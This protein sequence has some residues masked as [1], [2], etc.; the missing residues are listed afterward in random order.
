[1]ILFIF[2]F[3]YNY[4]APLVDKVNPR[5]YEKE[6]IRAWVY[7]TDKGI[8]IDEYSK[9]IQ[10]VKTKMDMM[11]LRR[12]TLRKG[13]IDYGDIPINEDYIGEVEAIGGL[14]IKKS[15][16][17]NAASFW[18]SRE[19]LN[20]IADLNFVYKITPVAYYRGPT[21]TEV[22]I[23]DTAIYG[24]SY[25]QLKMFN[26]NKLHEKTILGSN[27]KIGF[28]DT[29]LRKRHIALSNI[30]LIAE[31]DFLGGDQ[32]Y[33]E[34]IPISE[35]S[36]VYGGVVAHNASNKIYLFFE[37]D[38]FSYNV[39]TRDIMYTYS[40]DG[41]NEWQLIKRLTHNPGN[42][43]VSQLA[44][45][46]RDTIFVFYKD[47]TGIEYLIISDTAVT[48]HTLVSGLSCRE[49]TAVQIDDTIYVFYQNHTQLFMKKGRI[50]GFM[51]E[52]IV[53]SSVWDIKHPKT[54]R[55]ENKIGIFYYTYSADSLYLLRSPIPVTTFTKKFVTFGRD[56]EAILFGD[57]T[58][59]IYKDCSNPPLLKIGF[60]KSLDFGNAFLSPIILSDALNS[61]GRISLIKVG[62]DITVMWESEG[63]IY[64]RTSFNN[65]DNFGNLDSL[66]KEFVY[67][68]TLVTNLSNI[69]KVYCQRGDSITDG[70]APDDPD[71]SH[72]R[73]GTEMLG[74]VGGYFEHQYWGVA[75]G[76]QFLVA[77]TENPNKAYE[78]PV[79]E[80]T[81]ISG[82]EWCE[83]K[84]V[85]I[86]SSSLGYSDW[87]EWPIDYDGRAS[88]ASL[89]AYEATKRGIIIVNASGNI[90]I[91][92]SPR[93]VIPGDAEGV[94]T[95]GGIDTL[96]NH[97]KSDKVYAG[98]YPTPGHTVKKP[99]IVCLSAAPV[100]VNPDTEDIYLYSFGTSGATAIVSGI[101]ALLL[102]GHPNWNVDSVR[103]A[104]FNRASLISSPSDSMGY[105][106]PDALAAF[107]YSPSSIDTT[108][109]N[110]FLTPYPNPFIPSQ[111][112][113]I[114]I[115]F[116]LNRAAAVEIR[117]Y[118]VN[119]RIIKKEERPGMLQPG[120][121]TSKDPLSPNAAFIWDG[122]DENE[123]YVPSGIYY[124]L[125]MTRGGGNALTKIAVVR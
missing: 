109:G 13:I 117:V 110:I 102:E 101:C 7:F 95:V 10:A 77:K 43:W 96:F 111:H 92:L 78:F 66:N 106:W 53:D 51:P 69:I 107:N 14:L 124:C 108:P 4:R 97:W 9:A 21:E 100:V 54:V 23:Q 120:R 115:P 32:I 122:K 34:N 64:F 35:K 61:I 103:N 91:I 12:R 31:Y 20:K 105:G 11:S 63:K 76:A 49:P 82:L 59:L 22:A 28:L 67:L 87:Y 80:D 46:G 62:N 68:P 116:K 8:K 15:K 19:E 89:A 36:G 113:Q 52:A 60:T 123:G 44:V 38:T 57:T 114:F 58:F 71:Y 6:H 26:I 27:V 45:C 119:G 73:H 118:S 40:T 50:S 112:G 86:I 1:M 33:V 24:F 47:N 84:G 79:E 48:Y 125:L 65:G 16:W 55:A 29:G 72:P 25:R 99:E 75:P 5:C 88:P 37:G 70:Y 42:W 39:P 121:Y 56:P 94:I 17:L 3:F 81:W 98:Y 90:D 85:D 93:I 41:G 74:I 104:L 18:I 83:S 2:C 30:K